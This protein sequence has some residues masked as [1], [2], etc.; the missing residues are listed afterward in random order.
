MPKILQINTTVNWNSTGRIAED[1]GLLM[2]SKGWES[3]IAYSRGK[4]NSKSHLIQ[5]GNKW[6]I[7][8]H[9]I[10]TRIYDNHGLSSKQATIN[11]VEQIKF[12]RPD[13]IHLHNIH[14]YYL[15]YQ[16]LFKYLSSINTPIVW[17]LH[18]CWSFTGHCSY[19]TFKKCERWKEGCYDC[20][21][22]SNYPASYLF[23]RSKKN[24][25]NKKNS[26]TS[27]K[28]MTIV[29]V[30]NWLATD[31]QKSFLGKF[32]IKVIHNGIDL[33]T[34][35]PCKPEQKNIKKEN[36]YILLG[37]AS[38]WEERKGLTDFI[39]LRNFLPDNYSI[40]LIGLSKKQ[41]KELPQ[42][43]LG[44]ERTSNVQ[45]LAQYYSNANVF[46]NPTWEDNYPTTNLESLACGTPVI[47][48][49]T[50]G[51][52]EAIDE[53]TGIIVEPGDIITLASETQRIC[54]ITETNDIR[55]HCR[56]R[57]LRLFDKNQRY[58][59]YYQLYIN[60]LNNL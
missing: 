19:Y 4:P 52:I 54:R 46:I 53:K 44:I 56:Q 55:N 18:D 37:V 3:Y 14:G 26:F 13:I 12:L 42:N 8:K 48:Y 17:T 40:V 5:I 43:I 29:P 7:Y 34:F 35:S 6:D 33:N 45:E 39:K 60:L 58:E 30:S 2:Q 50:G 25:H 47:T 1:I 21:Q 32:P 49:R 31:V 27:V 22:K 20:P 51:S 16:I 41:I 28:N 15:N 23:D 59:E 24:Y 57:A 36:K 9:G 10:Y 38:I 11:L